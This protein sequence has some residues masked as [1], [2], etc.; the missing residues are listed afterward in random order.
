MTRIRPW[1]VVAA[2]FFA[3]LCLPVVQ[4]ATPQART[5]QRS[6]QTHCASCHARDGSGKTAVGKSLKAQ[7]LRAQ[8][9]QKKTDAELAGIVREGKKNMPAFKTLTT[10]EVQDLITYI[11]QLAR[12]K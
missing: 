3:V 2:V 11:R 9:I 8:E 6:Y 10:R 1:P 5:P 12:R 7:D 4:R